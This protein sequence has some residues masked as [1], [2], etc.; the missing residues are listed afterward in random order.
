MQREQSA[1]FGVLHKARLDCVVVIDRYREALHGLYGDGVAVGRQDLP[2]RTIAD[3][4]WLK[5]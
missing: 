1:G 4:G 3:D 5:G 2:G